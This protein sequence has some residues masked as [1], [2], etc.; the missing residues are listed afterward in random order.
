MNGV[1][2]STVLYTRDIFKLE[3]KCFPRDNNAKVADNR[4]FAVGKTFFIIK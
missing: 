4:M 1:A 3:N 2:C